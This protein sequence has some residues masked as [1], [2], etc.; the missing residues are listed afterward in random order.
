MKPATALHQVRKTRL[1]TLEEIKQRNFSADSV[2][3]RVR[4][5]RT[6]AGEAVLVPEEVK[7]DEELENPVLK[8]SLEN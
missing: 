8:V 7:T 5:K 4:G 1:P 2:R 3:M 6:E